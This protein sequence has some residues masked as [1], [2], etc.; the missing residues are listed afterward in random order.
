MTNIPA[1]ALALS[2]FSVAAAAQ[3]APHE[4]GV[5][6]LQVALDGAHLHIELDSPL[7]NLVGFEHAPRNAREREAFDAMM[8]RLRD[9]G[10]LFELPAAAA[11]V[12]AEP[13]L[14]L[15]HG[16]DAGKGTGAHSDVRASYAFECS[17]PAQLS[18]LRIGL[19]DAFPRLKR[20][21]V[22]AVTAAGQKRLML[23]KSRRDLPL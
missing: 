10:A 4:H 16:P 17:A 15:P 7:D 5:A 23:D 6:T 21:R 9:L 12:A 18:K 19:F 20:L 22:D 1:I 14:A 11:C 8:R 13:E 3:H 2:L